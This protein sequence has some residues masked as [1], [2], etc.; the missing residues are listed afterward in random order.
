IENAPAT[1]PE[2]SP[3][4]KPK[5]KASSKSKSTSSTSVKKAT[6]E[7]KDKGKSKEIRLKDMVFKKKEIR[8]PLVLPTE[9][10]DFEQFWKVKPVAEARQ[11]QLESLYAGGV[12]LY[13]YLDPQ[14][15]TD[16]FRLKETVFPHVVQS[17]YFNADV[18]TEKNL[19]ISFVKGLE[20]QLTP[21]VIGDILKIP[22][23]CTEIYG[24]LWYDAL[25]VKK[26]DLILEMFTKKGLEAWKG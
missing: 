10:E 21:E 23:E 7:K 25:Q 2:P 5:S 12:N 20:L 18:H 11:Y 6:V 1:Q 19:I 22:C 13:K 16:I 9:K 8:I 14:G 17:F 15:W 26:N 3:I 4:S 24:P